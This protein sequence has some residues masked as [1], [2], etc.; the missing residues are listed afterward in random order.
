MSSSRSNPLYW[1][2]ILLP[3]ILGGLAIA[4]HFW[5][6]V[7]P[8]PLPPPVKTKKKDQPKK[9]EVK[10]DTKAKTTKNPKRPPGKKRDDTART[11]KVGEASKVGAPRSSQRPE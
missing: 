10:A 9:P 4:V 7:P 11:G 8:G 6:S 5:A 3:L 1:L 2:R